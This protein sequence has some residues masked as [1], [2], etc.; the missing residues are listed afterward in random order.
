MPA[1]SSQNASLPSSLGGSSA[2][3]G[4]GESSGTG[5]QSNVPTRDRV[6]AAIALVRAK[7]Q[8]EAAP[9]AQR[10][11]TMAELQS[12]KSKA[13]LIKTT[14]TMTSTLTS[15]SSLRTSNHMN[16]TTGGSAKNSTTTPSVVSSL[17]QPTKQSISRTPFTPVEQTDS[18]EKKTA[19]RKSPLP[20]K[21]PE[22]TFLNSNSGSFIQ[23]LFASRSVTQ[24]RTAVSPPRGENIPAG[25]STRALPAAATSSTTTKIAATKPRALSQKQ[26]GGDDNSSSS[27]SEISSNSV[28][29]NTLNKVG[30]FLDR[31]GLQT[32]SAQIPPMDMIKSASTEASDPLAAIRNMSQDDDPLEA[33]RQMSSDNDIIQ[34]R[35]STVSEASDAIE[36]LRNLSTNDSSDS[37]GSELSSA[38]GVDQGTL[39]EIGAFIDAI[40]RQRSGDQMSSKA[41]QSMSISSSADVSEQQIPSPKNSQTTSVDAGDDEKQQSAARKSV[42]FDIRTDAPTLAA[43]PISSPV[44]AKQVPEEGEEIVPSSSS[45]SSCEAEQLRT[46]KP[47]PIYEQVEALSH[48]TASHDP[49]AMSKGVRSTTKTRNDPPPTPNDLSEAVIRL[50]EAD[51]TVTPSYSAESLDAGIEVEKGMSDDFESKFDAEHGGEEKGMSDDF[52]SK[53]DAEHGGEEKKECDDEEETPALQSQEMSHHSNDFYTDDDDHVAEEVSYLAGIG[54]S[55]SPVMETP[56]GESDDQSVSNK[57]TKGDSYKSQILVEDTELEQGE[58]GFEVE[59][60]ATDEGMIS[61]EEIEEEIDDKED[62]LSDIL[63]D[64]GMD[65]EE[66]LLE[67][68]GE[69]SSTESTN[70]DKPRIDGNS[71]TAPTTIEA[72]TEPMVAEAE[73]SQL[74]EVPDENDDAELVA[75][76]SSGDS[77]TFLERYDCLE[78]DGASSVEGEEPDLEQ[79]EESNESQIQKVEDANKQLLKQ[80]NEVAEASKIVSEEKTQMNAI[81]E[82]LS[83]ATDDPEGPDVEAVKSN[84]EFLAANDSGLELARKGD[85]DDEIISECGTRIKRDDLPTAP[86]MK[87][88]VDNGD[89]DSIPWEL[90]DIASEETMKATGNRTKPRP[91]MGRR[92]ARVIKSLLSDDSSAVQ[93]S[94]VPME[95]HDDVGE[96]DGVIPP[97]AKLGLADLVVYEEETEGVEVE[98]SFHQHSEEVGGNGKEATN[99]GE[100]GNQEFLVPVSSPM[101]SSKDEKNNEFLC[102]IPSGV[103]SPVHSPRVNTEEYEEPTDELEKGSLDQ[104]EDNDAPVGDPSGRMGK[105]TDENL[106]DPDAKVVSYFSNSGLGE[107]EEAS[108]VAAVESLEW[109]EEETEKTKKPSPNR[110]Q[111][112]TDPPVTETGENMAHESTVNSSQD[113]EIAAFHTPESE[114]IDEEAAPE[115]LSAKSPESLIEKLEEQ[116]E[117]A[118]KAYDPKDDDEENEDEDLVISFLKSGSR[119]E[120]EN[121]AI[122]AMNDPGS[123]LEELQ[124]EIEVTQHGLDTVLAGDADLLS[125]SIDD[126]HPVGEESEF[127]AQF[128]A[129][130]IE[131]SESDCEPTQEETL[132]KLHVNTNYQPTS[133]RQGLA[134]LSPAPHGHGVA[135]PT[136]N[137]FSPSGIARYFVSL[138]HNDE[139]FADKDT[140]MVHQFQ[141]L[142]APVIAGSKPSIIEAAQIRQA[143][144]KAKV[145]LE[146]VDR[147]LDF[148]EDEANVLPTIVSS[149]DDDFDAFAGWDCEMEELNQDD[150]IIGFL[151][152]FGA[153]KAATQEEQSEHDEA[154]EIDAA[155]GYVNKS[156]ELEAEN[157]EDDDEWW[158]GMSH[159][160]KK[161]AARREEANRRRSD[162]DEASEEEELV[163]VS[164]EDQAVN[165]DQDLSARSEIDSESPKK[166]R[167][168]TTDSKHNKFSTE[169]GDDEL[170][171]AAMSFAYDERTESA[172]WQRKKAM[173]TEGTSIFYSRKQI[174]GVAAADELGRFAF[175]K[176]IIVN[177]RRP[178]SLPYGE[179]TKNHPGFF[180]VDV[181]SVYESTVP[182][183]EPDDSGVTPWEHRDVK[184]RFLHERSVVFSR[185]WFGDLE[186]V[187]GNPKYK[188][189]FCKPKSMEMPME[190]I[191]DP[192]D[193]TEEWYT[194][195]KSPDERRRGA[196]RAGGSSGSSTDSDSTEGSY[197]ECSAAPGKSHSNLETEYSGSTEG[198]DS[199]NDD[200]TWEE[201]PECGVLINVKQKIGERVSRIHPDYTSSL[202]RSRWRKKYFPRGTF[203]YK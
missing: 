77:S 57:A 104:V 170:G 186:R 56:S 112:N 199:D 59:D 88:F 13:H 181:N 65:Y 177:I 54:Q 111:Y 120:D 114:E 18:K 31:L 30:N 28:D 25:G 21:E 94:V 90:R 121:L 39:A 175:G 136:P 44:Y 37:D 47:S 108:E 164:E 70:D 48:G 83:N 101:S 187:R 63:S 17:S 194:V 124:E 123:L 61:D 176:Q 149:A 184:Q 62:G 46:T 22:S 51:E 180:D 115:I 24:T 127:A 38:S 23:N 10:V 133:S 126:A 78:Q 191:P 98:T 174:D 198:C 20:V 105:D 74:V 102:P 196:D 167:R 58:V 64:G 1:V 34:N 86:S 130:D 91:I 156:L 197:T 193:W 32:R 99:D 8:K 93:S 113:D 159:L 151:S 26:M 143:A 41:S 96:T 19:R 139:S 141:K 128:A 140:K 158:K 178:W 15:G 4:G 165:V 122:A 107:D 71:N 161:A 50:R 16:T 203:P 100:T 6:A 73:K 146:V 144:R 27:A 84:E 195:W 80:E 79:N 40:E 87:V 160:E 12:L 75:Q 132:S 162:S 33:L 125:T 168:R 129:L 42:H 82:K 89:N 134:S 163:D 60:M 118:K 145:P 188:Q 131:D 45:S 182:P 137:V 154:V 200:D 103:A 157:D 173:A 92:R 85:D 172:I 55:L 152:R 138:N 7:Q 147:F 3:G 202:R 11:S 192:G 117:S 109:W 171:I 169:N 5:A 29:A 69:S 179:R 189:P 2:Q 153:A 106:P 36:A 183:F 150:E 116:I 148:A 110:D 9:S 66:L 142:V 76:A 95:S 72:V 185:N 14:N 119:D 166:G 97:D 67:A 201:A 81:H 53:V 155:F 52:E 135:S 49:P 68:L 35:S 190:N 43:S